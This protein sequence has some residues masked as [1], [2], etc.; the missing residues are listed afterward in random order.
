MRRFLAAAMIFTTS[1]D[2]SGSEQERAGWR[3]HKRSGGYASMLSYSFGDADRTRLAGMCNSEPTF[4]LVGGDYPEGTSKFTLI[5]DG[6]SWTLPASRGEHGR[7]LFVDQA[8]P[9]AAISRASRL[10]SFEVGRWRR[11][12]RP[13][14]LLREFVRDCTG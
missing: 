13:T 9:N 5:V 7:G 11:S 8:E 14:P 6:M 12:L 1:C 3:Y 10:I 4:V 2:L